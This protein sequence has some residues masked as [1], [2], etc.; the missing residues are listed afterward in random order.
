VRR[1]DFIRLVG[2]AA[3][4]PL[5]VRA[6][7]VERL[8]HIGVLMFFAEDDPPGKMDITAFLQRLEQLNWTVDHNVKIDIRWG[9][10]SAAQA[11]K[12]A[13]EL[14]ALAPDVILASTSS[15]TEALREAT[16]TLPIVFVAVVDPVGAGYV[17][18]LAKPGG[19]ITG[20]T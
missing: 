2:G 19:N 15:A 20:F 18:S 3:A 11:R 6:Q 5:A 1:R 14:V 16:R 7:Q 17:A 8:R 13:A 9:A 10:A 12:G 4:W